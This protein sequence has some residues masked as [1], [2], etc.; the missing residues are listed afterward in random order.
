MIANIT[1][2]IAIGQASDYYTLTSAEG[3]GSGGIEVVK[4]DRPGFHGIKTPRAYWRE[5]IMRMVINVRAET[6][7]LYET[8]RRALEE[9]FDTPRNGL[10]YLKFTT[11]AGLTLQSYCHLN[12]EIQSPLLGG[13]VTIGNFRIELIAEDPIFYSQTLTET[14]VTFAAGS[15]AVTN[16]GN[17]PV[18]PTIRVHGNVLNP[19]ITNT[20]LGRTVSLIGYTISAGKYVDI[21]MLNETVKDES[22]NSVYSYVNSDDFFWIAKGSN[23]I[24]IS[25]TVG[26]SGYRKATLSFRNGYLGV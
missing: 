17:A 5:R 14:D 21:D 8:K 23:T 3:F 7:A 16:S 26:G 9:A 19:V 2:P 18:F 24:T 12:A 15:G 22:G 13:E 11:V 20:T 25:G 4:W 10:T 1:Y 6:S